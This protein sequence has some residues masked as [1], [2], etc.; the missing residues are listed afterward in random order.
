MQI[1]YLHLSVGCFCL[2]L[3]ERSIYLFDILAPAY[4]AMLVHYLLA[5]IRKRLVRDV[6]D[7]FAS[8]TSLLHG[9]S[10]TDFMALSQNGSSHS[11]VSVT[12]IYI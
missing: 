4:A 1:L 3:Y 8:H 7:D 11:H 6:L 10:G 9:F 5:E 12:F 2:Y